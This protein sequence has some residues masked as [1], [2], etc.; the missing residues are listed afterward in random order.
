MLHEFRIH[1][2]GIIFVESKLM[3][4]VNEEGRIISAIVSQSFSTVQKSQT[5]FPQRSGFFVAA[6]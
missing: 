5:I 4:R 3:W 2:L 6:E 1:L